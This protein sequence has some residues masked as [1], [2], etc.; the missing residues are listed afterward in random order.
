MGGNSTGDTMKTRTRDSLQTP[1][2]PAAMRDME[3]RLQAVERRLAG[4]IGPKNSLGQSIYPYTQ[5][6]TPVDNE[7]KPG[8]SYLTALPGSGQ[9]QQS[10]AERPLGYEG[11]HESAVDELLRQGGEAR[12]F[13]DRERAMARAMIDG[14][15]RQNRSRWA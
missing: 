9:Q 15:E 8:Y 1:E 13:F 4:N 5:E 3:A 6:Q 10:T 7:P 14:I 2:L 12:K 11:S